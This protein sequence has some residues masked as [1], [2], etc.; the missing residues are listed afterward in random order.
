MKAPKR[1]IA[2][3]IISDLRDLRDT[4]RAGSALRDKYNV[5]TVRVIPEPRDYKPADVKRIRDSLG[6]SQPVF[7]RMVGVSPALVRAWECGQRRPALIARRLLDRIAADP[8]PWR[9]MIDAA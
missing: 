1:K 5:R 7:A 6:V 8:A 3:E 4:L 9:A 2:D